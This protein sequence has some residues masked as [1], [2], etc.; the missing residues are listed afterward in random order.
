MKILFIAD[1]L[2]SFK[3]AKD[4][5]YAMMVEAAKRG[6]ELYFTPQEGLMWKGGRVLGECSRIS[7]TGATQSWYRV[8]AAGEPPL[9]E[10]DAVLMRK[11]PPFD[12]EYVAST[13]LLELAKAQGAKVFNDPRAV[14]DHSEKLAIARYAE[15]TVPTLVTRVD[16]QVHEF[17]DA[18]GDVVLKPLDGMGGASIFRVTAGDPNRNVI[19]ETLLRDGAKS[20]MAQRYIPE[21]RDGDKRILVIAGKPVPHCLARIP[22]PGETRGNLAAGG[23]GVARSLTKRDL[24]IA[25]ALGP[26]LAGQGLLLVGLDVIGDWL[27]EINVT[28]PTCFREITDQTGF[29]VAGMFLDALEAAC[30][31]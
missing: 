31:A 23:T 22:K 8:E 18:Q 24:E 15:F 14:R 7:L 21:I 17:I 4:S 28:S 30:K 25:N 12:V 9:A 2:D 27:T 6:H 13:W 1:P 29:N 11:D 3:L 16:A 19:V 5:T 10:F 20:V 26:E